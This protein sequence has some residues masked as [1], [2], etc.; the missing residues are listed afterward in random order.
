MNEHDTQNMIRDMLNLT[1]ST[2]WRVNV[3]GGFSGQYHRDSHGGIY[4]AKPSWITT[5]VPKGFPDLIGV[6]P[7]TINSSMI[8]KRIGQ[9]AFIEVKSKSGRLSQDQKLMHQ[10]LLNNGAI[11][12]V[13]RN[14][15]D[16]M[17]LIYG[18]ENNDDISSIK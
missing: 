12:G 4:I 6:K 7:L 15:D 5:G 17:N 1:T 10:L 8:G 18:G 14:I 11:G 16:A 3:I 2:F 9:F 13:A